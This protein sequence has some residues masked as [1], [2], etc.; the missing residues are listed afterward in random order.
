MYMKKT[1]F[2][3]V[4]NNDT[5]LLHWE[6][7]VLTFISDSQNKFIKAKHAKEIKYDL[8]DNFNFW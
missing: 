1:Y 4:I 3:F 7:F 6:S 5:F 8:S 2:I